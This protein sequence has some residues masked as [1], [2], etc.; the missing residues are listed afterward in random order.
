MHY[1]EKLLRVDE[2]ISRQEVGFIIFAATLNKYLFGKKVEFE[3]N[4]TRVTIVSDRGVP[5]DLGVLSSGEKQLV[6]LFWQIIFGTKDSIVVIDEPELSL[7]IDWQE[8]L[9]P[10][11][12]SLPRARVLFAV[13]HSPF[14]FD[15]A[16]REHTV[17]IALAQV[18]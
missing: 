8:R 9:L 2:K 3:R 18:K 5:L 7:S 13:T 1:I 4:P 15:N 14:I 16:M 6:S 11:I 10:D 12:V 17:D